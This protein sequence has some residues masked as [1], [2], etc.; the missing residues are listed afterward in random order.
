[1][2]ALSSIWS[3]ICSQLPSRWNGDITLSSAGTILIVHNFNSPITKLKF[4]FFESG[5]ELNKV[6]I[7]TNYLIIQESLDTITIV[8]ISA[9]SRTFDS[10]IIGHPLLVKQTDIDPTVVLG[11]SRTYVPRTGAFNT[12]KDDSNIVDTSGGVSTGTLPA[13]PTAG[14][15]IEFFDARGSFGTN[16]LTLARNG[17]PINGLAS[18]YDCEIPGRKWTATYL[19]VTYGWFISRELGI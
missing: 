11:S 15:N 14:D 3:S 18:D 9:G 8:N 17:Q 16:K 7:D 19:D 12:V 10:L 2:T 13:T 4:V 5:T 1:M 6:E